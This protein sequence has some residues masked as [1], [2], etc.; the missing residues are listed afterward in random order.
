MFENL[1]KRLKNDPEPIPIFLLNRF[2]IQTSN[3]TEP[4]LNPELPETKSFQ[5]LIRIV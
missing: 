3:F 4:A 5:N 1:V 2:T